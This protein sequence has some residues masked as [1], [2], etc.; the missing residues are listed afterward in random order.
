[1]KL[2]RTLV[3]SVLL[4]NCGTW[5]MTKA[6]EHKINAFHRKQL[7]KLLGIR[8]PTK[9][10][11]SSLYKKCNE[12]PLAIQIMEIR[13]QLFGHV[14]RR[15][16]NIPANKAMRGYFTKCGESFRGRPPTTLPV[17][18]NK[19]LAHVKMKLKTEL[20]LERLRSMAQDR[21]QWRDF[22]H[23]MVKAAEA[24]QSDDRDAKGN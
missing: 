14:L 9:I 17:V 5:A 8:Y 2:Y 19:D 20:D 18:L 16:E 15:N 24:T 13:W 10:S 6:E 7:R 11:N 1:M 22:T 4:Y 21:Q 12:Q 23:R 3:K